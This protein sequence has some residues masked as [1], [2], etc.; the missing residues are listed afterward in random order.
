MPHIS[1]PLKVGLIGTGSIANLHGNAYTDTEFSEKVKLTALCDINEKSLKQFG[2]LT[3]VKDLYSDAEKM[4]KEGDIDAPRFKQLTG[5]T[6]KFSIPLLEY[7]DKIKLTLRVGDTRIL[8]SK[9][10]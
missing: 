2:E 7:F 1:K 5:L 8:R 3:G 10:Q 9:K 6:R 4:I